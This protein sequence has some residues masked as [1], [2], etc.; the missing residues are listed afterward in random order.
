MIRWNHLFMPMGSTSGCFAWRPRWCRRSPRGE[1]GEAFELLDGDRV[2][3]ERL[4]SPNNRAFANR[5]ARIGLD[6]PQFDPHQ[7]D[8]DGDRVV[9]SSWHVALVDDTRRRR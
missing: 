6:M 1:S 2:R 8:H 4:T 5:F 9:A 7:E 3:A